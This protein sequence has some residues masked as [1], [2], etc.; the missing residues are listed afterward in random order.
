MK[1]TKNRKNKDADH[2]A[3]LSPGASSGL[4]E[5]L[6]KFA[7]MVVLDPEWN[8]IDAN[9]LFAARFDPE[10][11]GL[12]GRNCSDFKCEATEGADWTEAKADVAAGKNWQG[13]LCLQTGKGSPAWMR[14][15]IHPVLGEEGMLRQIVVLLHD[16]TREK[17]IETQFE[18]S[19]MLSEEAAR[20]A[21]LGTWEYDVSG[22]RLHWS[23][24][25]KEIHEV[26][27][28]FEPDLETAVH[29]YKPGKSRERMESLV[30][31]A[32]EEGAH[33]DEELQI[34]TAQGRERWVRAIGHAEHE[35]GQCIRIFGVFQDIT[36]LV[37]Q[38]EELARL[39]RSAEEANLA[40]SQFL[41]NMSHEIRTPL[42]GIIGMADL[43][44][45]SD[46]V[47]AE[48]S[49]FIDIIRRSGTDLLSLIN[50][51]LDFSKIEAGRMDLEIQS[52]SLRQLLS[53]VFDLFRNKAE[54]RGLDFNCEV[55]QGV[56]NPVKGDPL[57]IRQVLN[58]LVANAIKFTDKGR[59]DVRVD[60]AENVGGYASDVSDKQTYLRFTVNDT[61]IG[62]EKSVM[63][64]LF[65]EFSQVDSST[66]RIYGGSGLGLAISKN[67][68]E[69][70]GGQIG[71]E[72]EPGNGSTFWF[73][74]SLP[75]EN[76]DPDNR[77]DAVALAD[78]AASTE[79]AVV[80]PMPLPSGADADSPIGTR[81][82][83]AEDNKTNQFLAAALFKHSGLH[84]DFVENGLEALQALK[85]KPYDLILMDVQ[86]PQMDGNE[87]TRRIRAGQAGEPNR[88]VPILA[89]TAHTQPEDR[90]KCLDAGMNDYLAKPINRKAMF[91]LINAHLP[92]QSAA[93]ETVPE[94]TSAG[95]EE[96]PLF[97]RESFVDRVLGDVKIARQ[98]ALRAREDFSRQLDG[99]REAVQ[100]ADPEKLHFHAHGLKGVAL[101]VE[102]RQLAKLAQTLQM[103]PKDRIVEE[104]AKHLDTLLSR[105]EAALQALDDFCKT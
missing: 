1:F 77:A 88:H 104:T 41:A 82:L 79:P 57:R 29:F 16:I 32:I 53:E 55:A 4:Y 100:M 2:S 76:K 38:R 37:E 30:R 94:D 74:L 23:A 62:I 26:E 40:K 43:L 50:D 86:M 56:P 102:C 99:V 73:R 10:G 95:A 69:L 63:I 84:L 47:T 44:S 49:E 78:A 22:S 85:R 60:P 66:S 68:V 9:D 61:G 83:F 54:N 91:D 101:L 59:I 105:G 18:H 48:H 89:V 35:N 92:K 11:T 103:L 20:V 71:V 27:A 90:Q 97:D 19:R 64:K 42:N 25:T 45:E 98:V 87:A 36:P 81:I 17:R 33:F 3:W 96:P 24:T 12:I 65:K 46:G 28:D 21:R 52:F 8:I 7:L 72:S 39:A 67:L 58:N 5:A 80:E 75:C 31:T 34:V 15:L 14:T 70:M 13:E 6:H 93:A 51:I